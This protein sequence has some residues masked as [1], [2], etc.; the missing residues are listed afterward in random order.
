MKQKTSSMKHTLLSLSAFF[1]LTNIHAQEV[2]WFEPGHE[3]YYNVYCLL[4]NACGYKHYAVQ[5][6]TL[7][8]AKQGSVLQVLTQEEMGE[9]QFETLILHAGADTVFRYSPEAERWHMLYDMGAQVGDIWNIQEEEFVGYGE[10]EEG[11][12]PWLFRVE[13]TAVDTIEIMGEPR[14]RVVAAQWTDGTTA[15][16]FHFGYNT[17]SILEGVGPIDDAYGLIGQST[18]GPLPLQGPSFQCFLEG[19]DLVYGSADAPCNTLSNSSTQE[20]I[21]FSLYPN[22]AFD[23][24]FI[25]LPESGGSAWQLRIFDIHG[26]V[27]QEQSSF[28]G[29][30]VPV[31]ALPSGIYLVRVSDPFGRVGVKRFIKEE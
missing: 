11:T 21:A 31:Q 17:G 23:Q 13:V 15:S 28:T 24:L 4:N 29:G 18:S 16:D 10:Y 9:P 1:L 19:G 30:Y 2:Q 8:G 25:E 6:D 22:P 27:V 26:R 3:W 5:G 7:I 14:R 12:I 20:Q